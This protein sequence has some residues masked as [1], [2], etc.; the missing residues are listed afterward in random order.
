[1][2]N[3]RSALGAGF[4]PDTLYP[5]VSLGKFHSPRLA[6][7]LPT[8]SPVPWP[9]TTSWPL[10]PGD[11]LLA[12]GP[13][14]PTVP[15]GALQGAVPP[16][17]VRDLAQARG[18][19][20]SLCPWPLSPGSGCAQCEDRPGGSSAPPPLPQSLWLYFPFTDSTRPQPALPA[21]SDRLLPGAPTCS[22]GGSLTDGGIPGP[23]SATSASF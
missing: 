4:I 10:R 9:H 7:P 15:G 22:Q 16:P 18:G 21:G 8:G 19:S 11:L 6:A 3:S 20:F 13:H 1:M 12:G 5:A 2:P 17:W 14:G 23:T